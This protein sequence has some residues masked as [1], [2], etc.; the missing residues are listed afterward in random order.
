MQNTIK[1]YRQ[2][3][4]ELGAA[5]TV[6]RIGV[7]ITKTTTI[8]GKSLWWGWKARREMSDPALL[9]RT[10]GQWNSVDAF[11]DH[12]AKRSYTSF[13]LPHDNPQ[14]TA[15]L[16][17]QNFPEHIAAILAIADAA[18][19][20]EFRLVGH[21]VQFPDGIDWHRDPF[22]GWQWPLLHMS[23]MG[24]HLWSP[25][26]PADIR[27]T[28][29]LNR[30]QYFDCLGIAYWLTG[31]KRYINALNSQIQSWIKA[32]PVQHGLNWY[33][34][35]EISLRLIA[36]AVTF[37]FVRNSKE[38]REETGK[39]FL[40]SLWQQADFL[41]HHLQTKTT[42]D[43]PNNHILGELT[44]LVLVGATFP[45]FRAAATWHDTGLHLLA[46][47]LISQ[48]HLDG[49]N[50][51][52]ATGYHRF[53]AEFLLLIVASSH[54]SILSREPILDGTLERMIDYILA[55]MTPD[56]F[57]PMW[58]DADYGR[59]LGLGQ[60]K[61]FWDFRPILSSGAAL[62][63]RPDWKYAAN[64]FDEESFWL[65]GPNGLNLWD[66]VEARKPEQASR[67]FPNAGINIIRDAW[68][69]DT[70]LAMM[71]CGPFGLG[72]EGSCSH[73]HCDLLSFVLWMNG[74]PLLVDS[75]SYT[76]HG[77]WRDHFRL[78]AAHNT[79]M[80]DGHEQAS[81]IPYFNWNKVPEARCIEWNEKQISAEL[82][83]PGEVL[84]T[85]NLSHSRP[86]SWELVDVF[87]GQGEHIL[88]WFFHF[89]PGLTIDL[90]D[91]FLTVIK[92][93]CPFVNVYFPDDFPTP[94]LRSTWYSKQYDAKEENYELHGKW[95]GSLDSRGTSFRWQ[96]Q[97]ID[98]K[99][100]EKN[101]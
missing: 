10:I 42:N 29:E 66:Q 88:E 71:R 14:E 18:C 72:N 43:F 96:F 85:R 16:L 74:H 82:P 69:P 76:Y 97:L 24:E 60:D 70:D 91:G 68:S 3:I 100:H 99:F 44:G 73:S 63:E 8:Y 50:K 78:T 57:A 48:T 47:Q 6:R 17:H 11:L 1:H 93:G 31:D 87:K 92:D 38:F 80:V 81:P 46:E 49:V 98:E 23:R 9:K 21:T 53:V 77:T 45:E 101:L 28:W 26:R 67:S 79:V 12:L 62:F 90:H 61:D 4:R 2:R 20:N 27:F 5:E 15:Q 33:S 59:V 30:H 94:Q 39:I 64:R 54:R 37:Q 13:L 36:W 51:E 89:A 22:T 58:G 35:L 32:N 86:G 83:L 84:F 40:K 34:S 65:L 7:R 95:I 41:I 56:G 55:S 25:A 19:R 52:Q 75:G